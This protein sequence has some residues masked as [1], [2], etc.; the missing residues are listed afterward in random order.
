MINNELP[1]NNPNNL[2][3]SERSTADKK[4]KMKD[5]K[6]KLRDEKLIL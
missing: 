2:K 6:S 4:S 1:L 5:K 3:K